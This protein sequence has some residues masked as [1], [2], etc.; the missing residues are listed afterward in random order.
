MSTHVSTLD[1][2]AAVKQPSKAKIAAITIGNG[3]EFFDFSI[4]TFFAAIIGRQFS[5]PPRNSV[6]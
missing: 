5:P 4:Y 1:A 3:L 2:K 6:R